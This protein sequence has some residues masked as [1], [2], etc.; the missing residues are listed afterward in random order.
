[1]AVH[2]FFRKHGQQ[3]PV[4]IH[5]LVFLQYGERYFHQPYTFGRSGLLPFGM[6]PQASILGFYKV[7]L[8]Q[9]PHVAVTNARPT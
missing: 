7:L 2:A 5:A 3:F 4:G 1:M 6:N 8:R 9:R